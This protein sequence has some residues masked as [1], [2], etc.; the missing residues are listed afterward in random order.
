MGILDKLGYHTI[1]E[2]SSKVVSCVVIYTDQDEND[3]LPNSLTTGKPI[4][5]FT[6]F[7]KV[8]ISVPVLKNQTAE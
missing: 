1:E 6:K 2:Q 5:G 3:K 8:P 7:Y 4:E